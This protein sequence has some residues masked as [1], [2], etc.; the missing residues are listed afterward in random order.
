MSSGWRGFS[1]VTEHSLWKERWRWGIRAMGEMGG[2][3]EAR[4]PRGWACQQWC[5]T[6]PSWWSWGGDRRS[7]GKKAWHDSTIKHLACPHA[8][9]ETSEHFGVSILRQAAWNPPGWVTLI[10]LEPQVHLQTFARWPHSAWM[11]CPLLSFKVDQSQ[12]LSH[13]SHWPVSQD[14]FCRGGRY[15]H[16]SRRVSATSTWEVTGPGSSSHS[17]YTF[18]CF[19]PTVGCRGDR[20]RL[21]IKS[22]VKLK[23]NGSFYEEYV[24]I[25]NFWVN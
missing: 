20:E 17:S 10:S 15:S 13:N 25:F 1:F 19:Q 18:D 9:P 5:P 23:N 4:D 21:K 3:Y 12:C 6:G 7:S 24:Y 11:N 14:S 2:G 22:C 8:A 16:P